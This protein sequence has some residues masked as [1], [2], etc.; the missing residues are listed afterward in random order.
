VGEML[1]GSFRLLNRK[2][3]KEKRKKMFRTNEAKGE[4]WRKA[5]K[6][7]NEQVQRSEIYRSCLP[8]SSWRT[9]SCSRVLL[10]LWRIWL[11]DAEGKVSSRGKEEGGLELNSLLASKV[12][13]K[14]KIKTDSISLSLEPSC[15]S[16]QLQIHRQRRRRRWSPGEVSEG[17]KPK[18]IDQLRASEEEEAEAKGKGGRT[19]EGKLWKKPRSWL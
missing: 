18:E 3:G 4:T 12:K 1:E 7:G 13:G 16:L 2:G 8:S 19:S 15:T 9:K 10:L 14:R 17:R 11:K 6:E 5:R